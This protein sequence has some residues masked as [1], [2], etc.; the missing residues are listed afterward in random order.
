MNRCAPC[1]SGCPTG[2]GGYYP[3]AQGAMYQ[4]Y[5]ASQS[6][7][8]PGVNQTAVIPSSSVMGAPIMASPGGGYTQTVM[9][10][11]NNLPTF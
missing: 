11:A 9:V 8:L 1:N 4:G 10:P 3:P 7:Y 5:D 2:G 6:A